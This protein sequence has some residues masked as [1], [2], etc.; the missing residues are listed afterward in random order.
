MLIVY[1][2]DRLSKDD[3]IGQVAIPLDTVDFGGEIDEWR[4]IEPPVEDQD[5]VLF[6]IQMF[7]LTTSDHK[8]N[9]LRLC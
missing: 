2:F 6:H 8:T 3:R 7:R 1:D 4:D 5:S 9:R